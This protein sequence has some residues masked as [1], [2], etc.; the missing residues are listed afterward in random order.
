V[1]TGSSEAASCDSR[2]L[3]RARGRPPQ[4]LPI[5]R[6]KPTPTARRS[7]ILLS[8]QSPSPSRFT[9]AQAEFF[10]PSGE[11]PERGAGQCGSC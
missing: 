7:S 6:S 8:A 1:M 4:K 5:G 2:G 10:D 9:A 11:R 3:I